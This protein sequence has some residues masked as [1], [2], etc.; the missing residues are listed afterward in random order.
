[1]TSTLAI[2][3][4]KNQRWLSY[5]LAICT[6]LC[7]TLYLFPLDFL[8]GKGGFFEQGDLNQH[9]TGWYF[10]RQD[11]WRFPLLKT[12]RL[13]HPDG[14]SIVFTD[15]IPIAAL[16]FKLWRQVLPADFHYF[17]LWHALVFVSQACSAV[18]LMR[19][20]GLQ[21]IRQI[22]IALVF[23]LC[24]PALLWR[25]GHTALM[26]HSLLLLSLAY[27][28]LAKNQ[29]WTSQRANLGFV[30]TN[31]IALL[32]HPYLLVFCFTVYIAFLLQQALEHRQYLKQALRLMCFFA[33]LSLVAI[34]FGYI[35]SASAVRGFGIFSMN[36]SAPICGGDLFSCEFIAKPPLLTADNFVDATGGQQEGYNYLGLGLFISLF[37]GLAVNFKALPGMMRG[38][39][40]LLILLSVSALYA[41]SNLI[42]WGG[43]LILSVP[44]PAILE[45]ISGTFRASGRFFWLPAYALLFLSLYL[46]LQT[47][48]RLGY[49]IL[50]LCACVQWQDT[51]GLRHRIRQHINTPADTELQKWP[52][53]LANVQKINLYPSYACVDGSPEL[54]W[55]FQRLAAVNHKLLNTGY[56]A[57]PASYCE[58]DKKQF[59]KAFVANDFYV[60]TLSTVAQFK[61]LPQGF[62]QAIQAGACMNWHKYLIC[63]PGMLATDW[64]TAGLAGQ[65]AQVPERPE[66]M[67]WPAAILPGQIGQLEGDALLARG[68][69]KSGFVSY[70]PY[71][72]LPKGKYQIDIIYSSSASLDTQV[73]YW[74]IVSGNAGGDIKTHA[75]DKIYGS[76]AQRKQIK[77]NLELDQGNRSIEVRNFY[78]GGGDL[79]IYKLIIE[80]QSEPITSPPKAEVVR[81]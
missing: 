43:D 75:S 18:F 3:L 69:D 11:E 44:L 45:K 13:N 39:W 32:V 1:M 31:L 53:L 52:A 15:S 37:F 64:Q 51:E 70:G 38:N 23:V 47:K 48:N 42:Y 68:N 71:V 35:S 2:T 40:I 22:M 74:D 16:F 46:L 21:Q 10:Y 67:V 57:R 54:Y 17:G 9:V 66:Q 24:W 25:L 58:Q 28:V 33:A 80:P 60:T 19:A 73:G 61:Q 79:A 20:L 8:L 14:V 59:D 55:Y 6:G 56:I 81:P 72:R 63:Q 78:S 65:I 5:A 34:V 50:A 7:L 27:Y 29:T 49:V 36:L 4:Q 30:I 41:C 62:V 76:A 26:T 12:L 77:I